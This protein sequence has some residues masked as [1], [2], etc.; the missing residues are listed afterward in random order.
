MDIRHAKVTSP[1]IAEGIGEV[2]IVADGD[3]VTGIYFP[4][5]WTKPDAAAFGPETD[6]ASDPVIAGAVDQL[7]DYL[8]GE[9]DTLDFATRADGNDF[10]KRV[11]AMLRGIPRGETMTYGQIA[12]QLGDRSLARVVGRA[13][14][15]NPLSIIVPCHRVVGAD[16][17][18]TGYAGGLERK[19]FLLELEGA[20]QDAGPTLF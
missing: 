8:R 5:H 7:R 2:T 11:W 16:G 6:A 1:R 15:H 10:E 18:L 3:L 19:R 9:R 12:E 13:V 17:S 14:G 4:G 20:L